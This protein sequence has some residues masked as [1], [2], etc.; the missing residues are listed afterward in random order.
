MSS[1]FYRAFEDRHR[2]SRELI[3]SRQR[4]YLPFL[5]GLAQLYPD[6]MVTDVGCGRGEWLE[7]LRAEGL[8][9]QGV[10][11]DDGMLL[12]C[13]ELGLKV[14]HGDA[15]AF[16]KNLPDNSQ[17]AV[18][19]LHVAEH[20]PFDI[21]QELVAQVLRVLRP[22]GLLILETPNPENLVVGTAG[23]YMDPTH[24][25]PLPPPLLAFLP[26]FYGFARV[27]TL[28]LQEPEI[29][30]GQAPLTLIDVLGGVS[31]DYAVIAQKA[32]AGDHS[33]LFQPPGW[34]A[35]DA[36]F[37]QE[38]GV[39]LNDL[40]DRHEQQWASR[41]HLQAVAAAGQAQTIAAQAHA[42]TAQSQTL[43]AQSQALTE[44]ARQAALAGL[45]AQ[46]AQAHADEVQAVNAQA[47]E[48][49][50]ERMTA[51]DQRLMAEMLQAQN[52]LL[53]VYQSRSW[54]VTRP[55]RWMKD[56]GQALREQGPRE[57]VR[58]LAGKV[59]GTG[60]RAALR[61]LDRHPRAR[62]LAARAVRAAGLGGFAEQMQQRLSQSAAPPRLDSL[63]PSARRIHEALKR[64]T[65]ARAAT[66]PNQEY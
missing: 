63:T 34:A 33:G 1:D 64:A 51:L 21:L 46:A 22:G 11:L 14:T 58:R 26:E 40:A 2:G 28:R 45:A 61:T 5:R 31:P 56:Q 52:Q 18:S 62:Q 23:F 7:L 6:G 59:L 35:I 39:N 32:I 50:F 66:P 29:V 65:A 19:G 44:L 27:K 37:A 24:Q 49:G 47:F 36:A 60:T 15:I 53:A 9:A 20:L 38:Y 8:T 48:R 54:R 10:D 57:R 16:L 43:T 13:R 25:R 30:K 12:A 4:V 55:L 42:L 41:F 17:L 3:Q